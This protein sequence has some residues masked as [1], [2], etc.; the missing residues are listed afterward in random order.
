[1]AD[2]TTHLLRALRTD[3]QLL[4]GVIKGAGAADATL[5]ES[6]NMGGGEIVSAKHTATGEFDLVFRFSYPELK[7]LFRPGVIGTTA[8]LSVRFTAFD[9]VAKTAHIVCEVGAVATD[10]ASTDTIHFQWLVRNSGFNK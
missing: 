9:P 7:S 10:P 4:T 6:G 3:M 5:P 8:G 1:M 2:R